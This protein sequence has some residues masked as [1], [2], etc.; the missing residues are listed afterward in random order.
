M[1]FTKL[2]ELLSVLPGHNTLTNSMKTIAM[3][4]AVIPD[5]NGVWPGQAGYL[6][7]YD[8]YFAALKLIPFLQ[9]QPIVTSAGS[10]GTSVTV[11]A[12]DWGALI[13]FYRGSSPI[14]QATGTDVLAVVPIPDPPHVVRVSMRDRGGYYGDVNTGIG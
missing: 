2:N 4:S 12:P 14:I 8:V 9:A 13:T 11:S 10:E 1:D 6:P 3:N 5:E 7:T